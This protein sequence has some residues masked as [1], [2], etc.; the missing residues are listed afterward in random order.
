MSNPTPSTIATLKAFSD[1]AHA[2][3]D[4]AKKV[5][6]TKDSSAISQATKTAEETS[7]QVE[8]ALEANS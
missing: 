4:D 8:K 7:A 1:A 2:L 3:I 6:A 5:A